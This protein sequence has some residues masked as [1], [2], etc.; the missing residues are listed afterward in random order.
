[1]DIGVNIMISNKI[2]AYGNIVNGELLNQ[3][4]IFTAK[5]PNSTIA[6]NAVGNAPTVALYAS[7]DG[8]SWMPFIVG[9]TTLTLPNAGDSVYIRAVS[10]NERMGRDINNYNSFSINGKVAASGNIQSLLGTAE[11]TAY[12]C[13]YGL[14]YNCTS[15]TQAPALPA[16]TLAYDCYGSMFKGCSSLT[17]A[18]EL[19]AMTLA[20]YCYSNMFKGCSS[21]T[22]APEL[23]AMTLAN[24]CYYGMFEG[25]ISLNRAPELPAM[26]LDRY[27]YSNMFKGCSSLTQAPE[28]PAE[29]LAIY[30]YS[31]MFNGCSSLTQA[32][33]LPAMTLAANC[34]SYMF[35]GCKQI[36]EIKTAQTSFENCNNWLSNVSKT[37][38]FYCP[39]ILGTNDTIKRGSSACPDGW[40]VVNI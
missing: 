20:T 23:P 17:K 32:P 37:G 14:F 22:K 10:T 4:L 36:N 15:L 34:Y 24:S 33:E 18:P 40:N 2:I 6:M 35:N 13:F 21:L 16:T 25:C 28:L 27:C 29:T 30:C 39:S 1:M 11:I 31:N 8:F 19:P 26:T 3:N 38:T 7:Y 12:Y 9:K 5:Q